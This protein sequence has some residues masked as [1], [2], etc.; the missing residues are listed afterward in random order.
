M[1]DRGKHQR[2]RRHRRDGGDDPSLEAKDAF[3]RKQ[4]VVQIPVGGRKGPKGEDATLPRDRDTRGNHAVSGEMSVQWLHV[5]LKTSSTSS[6]EN[7]IHPSESS[8]RGSA[9]TNPTRIHEDSGV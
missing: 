3:Q 9:A 4:Q 7:N 8:C 1:E 5:A 6:V 2:S